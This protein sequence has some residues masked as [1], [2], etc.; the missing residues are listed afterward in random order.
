MIVWPASML[1]LLLLF[2]SLL[3]QSWAQSPQHR[4]YQDLLESYNPLF[5]PI[6]T[7]N[8]TQQVQRVFIEAN[9]QK[10]IDVEP[11]KVREGRGG[12]RRG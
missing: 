2:L 1:S 11:R 5:I 10:I 8:T 12:Q 7:T 4:L 6:V 3:S 9:L